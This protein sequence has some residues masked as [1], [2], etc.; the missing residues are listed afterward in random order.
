MYSSLGC[1][2]DVLS[3]SCPND[4]TINVS[5]AYYG[6]YDEMCDEGCC[7]PHQDDCSESMAENSI[8]EWI[9]LKYRCDN[10][11]DCTY[12]HEGALINECEDQYVADYLQ[13]FY[14]CLPGE[15]IAKMYS[16]PFPS[17]LALN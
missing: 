1:Y 4:R 17:P 9:I 8:G 12:T 7:T 5:S 10:Q 16:P 15:Y 2:S 3:L 13:V 11:T 6:M 14:S